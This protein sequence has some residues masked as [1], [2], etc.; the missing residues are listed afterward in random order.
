LKTFAGCIVYCKDGS[1]EKY[2]GC[3]LAVHAPD[4][5]RLLG[6]EATYDERRI[7]GAFQYTYR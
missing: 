1:E 6:D 2:D 3:I 5:L 4:A 7:I